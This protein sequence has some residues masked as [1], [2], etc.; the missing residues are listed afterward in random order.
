MAA[1]PEQIPNVNRTNVNNGEGLKRVANVEM[2]LNLFYEELWVK[3][4][5][6]RSTEYV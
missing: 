4:A 1:L 2:T 3:D 6:S 5:T